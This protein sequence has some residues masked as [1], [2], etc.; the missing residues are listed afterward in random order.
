M[1]LLYLA[2]LAL[3][4]RSLATHVKYCSKLS[5]DGNCFDVD[6]ADGLCSNVDLS[7]NDQT[8]SADIS[9]G[10]CVFWA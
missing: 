2:T 5:L 10:N 3:T 1:K 6:V 9:G 7:V 8:H 4:G